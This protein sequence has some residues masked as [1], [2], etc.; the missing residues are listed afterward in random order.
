MMYIVKLT[1]PELFGYLIDT[2]RCFVGTH[3]DGCKC[4]DSHI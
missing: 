3:I 1:D 2:Q 4:C